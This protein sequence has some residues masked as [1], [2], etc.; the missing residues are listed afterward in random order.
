MATIRPYPIGGGDLRPLPSPGGAPSGGRIAADTLPPVGQPVR[1]EVVDGT[2]RDLQV[3]GAALERA[4]DSVARIA[5][6]EMQD[7]NEAKVQELNNQFIAQQQKMLYTDEG[8]FYRKRGKDAIESAPVA[9][10]QLMDLQKTLLDG[11]KNQYQKERLTKILNGH[12]SE[13][14]NGM[15]RFVAAQSTEWQKSVAEGK[16]ALVVNQARLD[17]NDWD[18]VE[19]LAGAAGSAAK[20]SAKLAGLTGTEAE[21]AMIVSSRS[22]VYGSAIDQMVQEGSHRRALAL[23]EKVKPQLDAKTNDRLSTQMKSIATDVQA[24]DWILKNSPNDLP[25]KAKEWAPKVYDAAVKYG[26]DSALALAVLTQESQGNPKAEGPPTRFGTAKGLM[27]TIDGTSA[28]VGIKD[29]YNADQSIDGGVNYLS[30]MVGK[31]RDQRLAL[32]AYNWGPGNVDNWLKT[33]SDPNKVPAETRDYVQK[34]QG[35]VKAQGVGFDK[36]NSND[37]VQK[38]SVDPSLNM[39]ERAMVVGKLT[40]QAAMVEGTRNA[41]IKGYD[42]TLE[43]STQLMIASPSSYKK[44]TLAALADGYE[45]AGDKSKAIN[46]RILA[47]NE[48]FLLTFAESPDSAQK[49]ILQGLLPGK[50]QALASG[51][52]AA[53]EKG[54]A[55]AGKQA[56]EELSGLKTA[57]EANLDIAS[58]EKK[59]R[60]AVDLAVKANDGVLA[61][62][63]VDF[64][65]SHVRGQAVGQA[66]PAAQQKAIDEMRGK[67]GSG[68][69]SN[70]AIEA[71]RITQQIRDKQVQE[72]AKDPMSAGST[73]YRNVGPLAPIGTPQRLE[74]A[75][76]IAEQRGL[77]DIS[78]FTVPEIAQIRQKI[79]TADPT[80]QAKTFG[81]IAASVPAR[82]I[83]QVAAQLAGKGEGDPL[84]RSYAAALSFMSEKDPTSQQLAG[85]ILQGAKIQRDLGE[86]GKK[87]PTGDQAWQDTLQARMGNVFR[88]M[89]TKVP[90]VFA[91]A[92]ASVYT[93]QMHRLGRQGEKIDTEVLDAA[94]KAV[95]GQAVTRNGQAFLPPVRGMDSY[96]VDRAMRSLSDGD[97]DGLRTSEGD[98]ITADKVIGRGILTNAGQ[99]GLYFVRIP[100]PRAGMDPR[101]VVKPDGTSWQLDLRPLIE[102][103]RMFPPGFDIA[104]E[105]QKPT[106]MRR[107]PRAPASPTEGLTP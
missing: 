35:Y 68:D 43:A 98:P 12:V 63:I 87:A 101:P 31:Y 32:M 67:I 90:A 99:E 56:R 52:I 71:V 62:D 107:G 26:V 14:T 53:D 45:A 16:Q 100:D 54:R 70:A 6:G 25:A 36:V 23:Y 75:D 22:A 65:D 20:E 44:G 92:I 9:T 47:A 84:S 48:D 66:P 77:R 19:G 104:T 4:S 37:L 13:V 105:G 106:E 58:M 10:E 24:D 51:L 28:A 38:A 96:E 83:P 82:M 102:R 88:D 21:T 50:A 64:Y 86:A 78:P 40:K 15:S 95:L 3:A 46:T 74:Q 69:Q 11:T 8:A 34:V 30:Q 29:P 42:D 91:D 103:A 79:D 57:A 39:Q 97:L 76:K 72:F 1:S 93:Y 27:Q 94:S 59:A 17:N 5:L 73:T 7:A 60:T 2:P 80:T 61:R 81:E 85:Q 33:G 18:K 41:A 49:R 89:G 55:E